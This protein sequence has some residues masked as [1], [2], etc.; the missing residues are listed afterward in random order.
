MRWLCCTAA[1][2]RPQSPEEGTMVDDETEKEFGE[3]STVKAVKGVNDDS[4]LESSTK[5]SSSSPSPSP[6][7]KLVQVP[8]S[9][10][11]SSPT[12]RSDDEND[13]KIKKAV[14][15]WKHPSLRD[16]PADQ[17]RTYLLGRGV[18]EKQIHEAWE[19]ILEGSDN[20]DSGVNAVG[21]PF[22]SSNTVQQQ[23]QQQF[24]GMNGPL[25]SGPSSQYPPQFQPYHFSQNSQSPPYTDMY[26]QPS[27]SS[28]GRPAYGVQ[29][30]Y[31]PTSNSAPVDSTTIRDEEDSAVVTFGQ[32]VSLVAFGSFLG[33]TAAATA[34]W[35]NGGDF[36]LLPPPTN[37]KLQQQ[38]QERM[39]EE[40]QKEK[41]E[42]SVER[43]SQ[44]NPLEIIDEVE[45]YDMED[46]N[47]L[48]DTDELEIQRQKQEEE[49]EER[50]E[51]Q[52]QKTIEC[53]ETLIDM[54][55][56]NTQVHEKL[57]Q[58]L[59]SNSSITDSSMDL[60][61]SS[62]NKNS[63][64]T[65]TSTKTSASDN[66]T[67]L[68]HVW[69]ELVEIK[70]ELRTLPKETNDSTTTQSW[71]GRAD[72]IITRLDDCISKVVA[73]MDGNIDII[74]KDKEGET[75][76]G[77]GSD[78]TIDNEKSIQLS[79]LLPSHQEGEEQ[80][81]TKDNKK[82]EGKSQPSTYDDSQSS[83]SPSSGTIDKDMTVGTDDI[84]TTKDC[85][86]KMVEEND[87]I[88]FKKAIQILY[89]YIHNLSSKP[90]MGRYR[91]IYIKGNDSYQNNIE[92]LIGGKE[93]LLSLGF[94]EEQQQQQQQN[95]SGGSFLEWLPS[96]AATT[97]TN[98]E[99]DKNEEEFDAALTN[100]KNAARC[101]AILRTSKEE[102]IRQKLSDALDVL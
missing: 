85:I 82:I 54:L 68:R 95:G 90:N 45:N 52:Q 96:S 58:K 6:P 89:L 97:S 102:N 2:I 39:L 84:P 99:K 22:P 1:V 83:P 26:Q 78:D 74:A 18:S 27:T 29:N 65:E 94:V 19:R 56:V 42:Q 14:R 73:A 20:D 92:T 12:G 11:S 9:I 24:L 23:Q 41:I 30:G 86:R 15:F 35:L 98:E 49:E 87:T 38:Q 59:S 28:Y 43:N 60:L 36:Q 47:Y 7:Q 44:E 25:Q 70:A 48:V 67:Y 91:K 88:Q 31:D 5:L 3:S 33:V 72:K 37:K 75:S 76:D 13:I 100:V 62:S 79:N 16:I 21:G 40:Y 101:L 93:F 32:G 4:T 61:R 53:V 10:V 50:E 51:L 17:K 77:G 46:E 69:M 80:V 66:D 63:I 57:L 64:N 71:Q 8:S 81:D 55:K 34:R